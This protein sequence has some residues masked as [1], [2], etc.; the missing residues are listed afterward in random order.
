M[1]T[2]QTPYNVLRKAYLEAKEYAFRVVDNKPE[3]RRKTLKKKPFF[4]RTRTPYGKYDILCLFKPESKK[5]VTW[6]ALLVLKGKE[7]EAYSFPGKFETGEKETTGFYPTIIH[8]HAINRYIERSHFKGTRLDAVKH[9]A[10]SLESYMVPD[11]VGYD[12]YYYYEGGCFICEFID[13]VLHYKTFIMNRQM[14]P[15]QRM[16][17]LRAEKAA[18]SYGL[19]ND[20]KE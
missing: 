11:Y 8:S 10:L 4:Y 6:H 20:N 16:L 2:E 5:D 12:M 17:S 19:N 15:N 14:Y 1:F 7:G 18:E 13:N 9:L 3:I